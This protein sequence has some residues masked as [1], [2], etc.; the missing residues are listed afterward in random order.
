M[1]GTK[2][3]VLLSALALGVAASAGAQTV[4]IIGA[5]AVS[6]DQAVIILPAPQPIPDPAAATKCQSVSPASY[7]DCVN[8]H[9]AGQ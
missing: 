7:W 9:N 6:D 3:S 2:L 4:E 1:Q 5:P 8:S